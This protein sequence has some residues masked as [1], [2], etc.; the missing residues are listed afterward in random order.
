MKTGVFNP[1][2]ILKRLVDHYGL[3]A[4]LFEIT[5]QG[6]VQIK[7][8]KTI[9]PV[10]Y[11]QYK[12]I[13]ALPADA[14]LMYLFEDLW[15]TREN[16]LASQIS[17]H[18]GYHEKINA[19]SCR[20]LRIEKK[21]ADFFLE[22]YHLMGQTQAAYHYGLIHQ[23]QVVAVA[24]FS[25]GRKMNR[26]PQGILSYELIRLASLPGITVTGSLSRLV[27]QFGRDQQ[28]GD[29]MTYVDPLLGDKVSFEKNGFVLHG[30]TTPV[31]I[32]VNT[33]T[34]QRY[35]RHPDEEKDL[36]S[37]HNIGNYKL[38]KTFEQV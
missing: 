11:Q 34:H 36:L 3:P 19:R 33:Q 6:H 25:K 1:V 12:N 28:A 32:W 4:F 35:F 16:I 5:D 37:F 38:V 15:F 31:Q 22:R 26:L 14:R 23:K 8:S 13:P 27:L 10:P 30:M 18:A 20:V 9:V 24:T 29:V 21:E 2:N 7:K 17:R